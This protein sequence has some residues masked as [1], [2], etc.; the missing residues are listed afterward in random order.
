MLNLN[1]QNNRMNKIV[2]L[3]VFILWVGDCPAQKY[4]LKS[5]DGRLKFRIAVSNRLQYELYFDNEEIILPSEIDLQLINSRLSLNPSV[6]KNETEA[7]KRR[8]TSCGG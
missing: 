7:G 1:M 3:L 6:K 2:L 5:P 4:E 8:Y